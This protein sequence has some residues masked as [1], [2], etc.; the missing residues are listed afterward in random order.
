MIVLAFEGAIEELNDVIS[1]LEEIARNYENEIDPQVMNEIAGI[2]RDMYQY[3][4][5]YKDLIRDMNDYIAT[6]EFDDPETK[7]DLENVRDN[8]LIMTNSVES[9]YNNMGKPLFKQFIKP[10][11]AEMARQQN[12][13][14][15]KLEAYM[16]KILTTAERDESFYGT[17]CTAMANSRNDI[18]RIFDLPVKQMK[19]KARMEIE[20][21]MH[22][23]A[24]AQ[25]DLEE[26]GE[27]TGFLAERDKNGLRTGRHIQRV[28]TKRYND[29][30]TKYGTSLINGKKTYEER[31]E[32]EN[33]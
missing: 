17:M 30:L 4:N 21:I 1:R 22:R 32:L 2:L 11:L 26:A 3:V 20:N 23:L 5:Y 18:L 16:E 14:D 28:D 8:L 25:Q 6:T 10:Y 9:K 29:D 13:N 33:G 15:D 24:K 12:M 7:Q 19:D 27:N 31:Q